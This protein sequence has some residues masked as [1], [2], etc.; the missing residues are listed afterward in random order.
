MKQLFA[1]FCF[2]FL[3]INLFAGA[4]KALLDSANKAYSKKNY[5]AS[6]AFYEKVLAK[7][8]EA[9]E[10]YYNLGNAYFKNRNLPLAILNYERAKKRKPEDEDIAFNLKMAN[11]LIADKIESPEIHFLSAQRSRLLNTCTEKTWSLYSLGSWMIFLCLLMIYFVS[12]R[13]GIRQLSLGFSLLFLLLSLSTF[14]LARECFKDSVKQ[15]EAIILAPNITAKG[16]PDNK[17]T[18]LFILHE[19]SKVTLLQSSGEWY[20]IRLNNGHSGWLPKTALE[21]I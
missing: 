17:G 19:G 8:V 2:L 9:P 11:Q 15:E 6:I 12:G 14:F 20:E 16:S 4:E 1:F 10:I 18:D 21:T 13:T 5:P 3:S 7:N